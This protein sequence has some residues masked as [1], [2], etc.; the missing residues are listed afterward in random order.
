VRRPR[1][2]LRFRAPALPVRKPGELDAMRAAGAVV[3]EMHAAIEAAAVDGVSTA[4]LDAVAREVLARRGATSNFLGYH[5]FTGVICASPNDVVIHGIPSE[6]VV[7]RDGDLLSIDCGAIVDGWHGDAAHSFV[8][9]GS[10]LNEPA[11]RVIDAAERA[12]CAAMAVCLPGAHVGDIGAAIAESVRH[13]GHRLA[14]GYGGHGIGRAMHEP[15]QIP[16]VGIAG[17]GRALAEGSTICIEP[18]V[19]AAPGRS[20]GVLVECDLDPDGW[21]VRTPDGSL[22][23]H[24]EHTVLVT[25][26]GGVAL[27]H[28]AL[29][30]DRR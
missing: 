16:N 3:A 22:A 5:G 26:T 14:D 28:L 12:L 17:T 11:Q 8:V 19:L 9:G 25:A 4:M 23:A 24:A 27:T 2:P 20:S 6:H 21:T 1:T 29:S 10:A 18:M 15:P 30:E 13:D 7:V